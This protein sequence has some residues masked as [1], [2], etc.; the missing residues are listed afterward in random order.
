MGGEQQMRNK[1]QQ[2]MKQLIRPRRLQKRRQGRWLIGRGQQRRCNG[3]ADD[4]AGNTNAEASDA[5]PEKTADAMGEAEDTPAAKKLAAD[6]ADGTPEQ[7]GKMIGMDIADNSA[8]LDANYRRKGN[9]HADQGRAVIEELG[10]RE[11]HAKYE[12]EAYAQLME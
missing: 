11:R 7:L 10:I 1:R 4:A 8:V 5:A 12:S 9:V 3:G 6:A 2:T